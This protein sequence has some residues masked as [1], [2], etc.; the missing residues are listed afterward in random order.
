MREGKGAPTSARCGS[1]GS[2]TRRC[3][4]SLRFGR[5]ALLLAGS[6]G[7]ASAGL[8][9]TSGPATTHEAQ[10]RKMIEDGAQYLVAAQEESG[11]WAT[12]RGPGITCL[13]LKALIGSPSVGPDHPVVQRGLAYVRGFQH[14]DGGIYSPEGLIK[15]YETS[16][17]L[18]MYARLPKDEHEEIIRKAQQFLA[19]LQWDE[20]EERGLDDVFYGG[21]GYGHG[22]RPDLSN[23]QMML[24]AL[25]DSGLPEDHPAYKRALVFVQRCQMLGESNDQPFAQGSTQGG[26]IY[27]PAND[28]E[29]KAGTITVDGRE[30]LRSYGSMTYAGFKSMLYAGLTPSDPR[31]EAALDWIGRHW[32]LDYNPNMPERQA[33][34][35]LY[36]YYHTFARALAAH[37]EPVLRD[38][39]GREHDW[40]KEL[41][42]K[43]ASL[44][45]PDGSWVNEEDR[46]MEGNPALTTAYSLLA[47]QEAAAPGA[48]GE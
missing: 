46:W 16:V 24:D 34:E 15:N 48:A 2:R 38:K 35:G 25:K 31:V 37:G 44:Q 32:T 27:S 40:R 21:A 18:S 13:V 14:D 43:L 7:A 30:E 4:D 10:R 39:V 23:T 36:Y 9:Q 17:A 45:R 11:G 5:A 12:Q 29:S 6:L 26:F 22:K 41:I 20:G 28:G 19:G 33:K 47:L 8:A 42:A 1:G 3:R